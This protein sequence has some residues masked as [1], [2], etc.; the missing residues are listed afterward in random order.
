MPFAPFVGVN[1]HGQ[2]TLLGCGLISNE[3]TQTFTWLFRTWLECMEGK[4]PI[5]IITGIVYRDLKPENVMIQENGHL[6]L[7]DFDLSTK[8]SAK[9]PENRSDRK[10]NPIPEPTKKKNFSHFFKFRDSGISP[11]DSVHHTEIRGDSVDTESDSVEKSNSF[12]GTEEYVAPEIILGHGHDFAVDWWCLGIMLYEMLYGKTPFRGE[13]RKETFYRILSKPP[14]LTG[15][16]TPL[17][18]LI[19]KLL[20]KDP[21][22]QICTQ[23]LAD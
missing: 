23:D 18:D 20:E 21:M 7:V 3:D 14:D 6:M 15:E 8:L 12:V 9:S 16:L 11:A 22:L 17:R 4:A 13:N 10:S 2:S 1:H 5:G 19:G